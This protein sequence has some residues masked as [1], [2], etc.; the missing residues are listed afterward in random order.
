MNYADAQGLLTGRCKQRRKVGNN[1]WLE[2]RD[3]GAIALK[4]H[5]TDILTY[6]PSGEIVVDTNGYTTVTTKARI[7]EHLPDPYYLY[8]KQFIWYWN[9]DDSEY[10]DGDIV[11]S[12]PLS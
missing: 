9:E 8:Q 5:A 7:N 1:T 12:N 10:S 2:R 3:N 4:L 6:K 11:I